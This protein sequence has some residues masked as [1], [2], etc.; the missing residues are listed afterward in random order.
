MA[1]WPSGGR[2]DLGSPVYPP[3]CLSSLI[4]VNSGT[5]RGPN[6]CAAS[7]AATAKSRM[8]TH[9]AALVATGGGVVRRQIS[10]SSAE[11]ARKARLAASA[12]SSPCAPAVPLSPRRR[13]RPPR[14]RRSLRA[15]RPC[16]DAGAGA[17]DR[18]A[19]NERRDD[20]QREAAGEM[21][22]AAVHGMPGEHADRHRAEERGCHQRARDGAE[23]DRGVRAGERDEADRRHLRARRSHREQTVAD[24]VVERTADGPGGERQDH[25]RCE[26][27]DGDRGSVTADV[28][29][30]FGEL[31]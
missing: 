23:G 18:Y 6:G 24:L 26:A 27:Q 19:G 20:H 11:T 3:K 16:R 2:G 17:A 29:A 21:P 15:A 13:A 10:P 25:E 12:E 28:V 22:G 5:A 9:I 14:A 7:A 4:L 8:A 30:Q 1:A 31:R